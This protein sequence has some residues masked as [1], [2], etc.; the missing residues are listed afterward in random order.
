MSEGNV[1]GQVHLASGLISG[2]GNS[3]S[4]EVKGENKLEWMAGLVLCPVE[5]VGWAL[6]FLG[7][8]VSLIRLLGL[9]TVFNQ[10]NGTVN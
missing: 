6:C 8:L 3:L 5:A 1:V 2:Q 4:F 10:K 9:G 7:S